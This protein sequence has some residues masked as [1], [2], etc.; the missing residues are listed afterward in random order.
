M[1]WQR[2]RSLLS[3]VKESMNPHAVSAEERRVP[4]LALLSIGL[5][6]IDGT[7][8]TDAHT[9]VPSRQKLLC[10][11]VTSR[12]G[13]GAQPPR[14]NGYAPGD[15]FKAENRHGHRT[16][17]RLVHPANRP[18]SRHD[19]YVAAQKKEEFFLFRSGL[20]HNG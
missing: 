4:A 1:R 5:L 14:H 8:Y 2:I 12:T 7:N 16:P 15:P 3:L 18:S 10:I 11:S 19:R 17:R 13:D 9:S 6:E 20:V